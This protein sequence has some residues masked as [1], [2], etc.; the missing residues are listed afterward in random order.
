MHKKEGSKIKM[1][2][3]IFKNQNENF[4]CTVEKVTYFETDKIKPET[5]AE[6]EACTRQQIEILRL[7][8]V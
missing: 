2:L 3:T 8:L 4:C 7:H 5:E 6:K 1:T